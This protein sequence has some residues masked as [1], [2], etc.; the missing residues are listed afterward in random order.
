MNGKDEHTGVDEH[1]HARREHVHA[2]LDCL[3]ALF[4]GDGSRCPS[5]RYRSDRSSSSGVRTLH[6]RHKHQTMLQNTPVVRYI[7]G[8]ECRR[9]YANLADL[10]VGRG[11]SK[12]RV[13]LY[14][15]FAAVTATMASTEAVC[16][17][18]EGKKAILD[19][20]VASCLY[21]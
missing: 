12:G 19:A 10:D 17:D 2:G 14:G 11:T 7:V 15:H 13:V 5:V 21:R 3:E 20:V 9:T 4:V 1:L 18:D 16:A 8:Y 6:A